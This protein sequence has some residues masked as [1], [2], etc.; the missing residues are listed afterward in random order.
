MGVVVAPGKGEVDP[1]G[2][3][4]CQVNFVFDVL[5]EGLQFYGADCDAT[6]ATNVIQP[7]N[8]RYLAPGH[9]SQPVT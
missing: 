2:T 5:R 3:K 1:V 8:T 4:S 6:S 9:K 7:E